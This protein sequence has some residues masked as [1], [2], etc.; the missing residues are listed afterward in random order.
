VMKI[1]LLLTYFW[2]VTF[3]MIIAGYLFNWL[4]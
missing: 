3:F 1:K 2:I 4:L